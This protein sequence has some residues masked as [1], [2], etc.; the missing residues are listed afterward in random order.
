[1]TRAMAQAAIDAGLDEDAFCVSD[2]EECLPDKV[3]QVAASSHSRACAGGRGSENA[4]KEAFVESLA[5]AVADVFVIA[6]V[7]TCPGEI[8]W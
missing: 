1:M 5:G 7:R 8:L 2:V 3:A 6:A 4:F